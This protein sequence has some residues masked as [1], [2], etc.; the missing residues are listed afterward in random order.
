MATHTP[1]FDPPIPQFLSK[2]LENRK[3]Y[4]FLASQKPGGTF[5]SLGEVKR[6]WFRVKIPNTD[7]VIAILVHFGRILGLWLVKI[8]HFSAREEGAPRG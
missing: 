8:A 3:K 6:L 1:H 2:T 5:Y 4:A 7:E